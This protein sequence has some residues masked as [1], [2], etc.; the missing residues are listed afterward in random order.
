MVKVIL[1]FSVSLL[2]A[3][4]YEAN[5]RERI[6]KLEWERPCA[7][8]AS[9]LATTAG[10]PNSLTCTNKYHRMRFEVQ[11]ARSGEEIGV[12]VVCECERK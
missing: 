12:L 3:C 2:S 8:D 6:R 1:F 5:E 11:H 4:N 9:L 10:S 7:D